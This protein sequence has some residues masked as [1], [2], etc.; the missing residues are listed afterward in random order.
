[1]IKMFLRWWNCEKQI[2]Q[3]TYQLRCEVQKLESGLVRVHA[4]AADL[5]DANR[6]LIRENHQI[7]TLVRQL[8]RTLDIIALHSDDQTAEIRKLARRTTFETRDTV[9]EII[10]QREGDANVTDNRG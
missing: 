1:M 4:N 10:K 7:G 3:A 9:R 5:A 8:Y 6:D 2:A